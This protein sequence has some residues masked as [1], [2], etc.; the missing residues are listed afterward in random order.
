M[1]CRLHRC[2]AQQLVGVGSCLAKNLQQNS[3]MN[4]GYLGWAFPNFCLI[5]HQKPPCPCPSPSPSPCTLRAAVSPGVASSLASR[6]FW[7]GAEKLGEQGFNGGLHYRLVVEPA[8][9]EGGLSSLC[10]G[11][12]SGAVRMACCSMS[13]TAGMS[14]VAHCMSK[15]KQFCIQRGCPLAAHHH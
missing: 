2:Q 14:E 11:C 9:L 6:H 10:H 12:R 7:K 5:A 13:G 1:A 15:S 4:I 3:M 8:R